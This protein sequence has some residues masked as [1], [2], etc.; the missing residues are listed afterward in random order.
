MVG[1]PAED[2]QNQHILKGGMVEHIEALTEEELEKDYERHPL[3]EVWGDMPEWEFEQMVDLIKERAVHSGGQQ[4]L[5]D[6]GAIHVHDGQDSGRL[7]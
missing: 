5:T 7:A 2:K 3:S 4:F 1:Q 6:L